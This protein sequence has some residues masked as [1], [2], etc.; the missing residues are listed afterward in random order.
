MCF[1][2]LTRPLRYKPMLQCNRN[3]ALTFVVAASLCAQAPAGPDKISLDQALQLAIVHNH[4]LLA[5][6]TTIVQNQ[7][8]EVQANVRP[9]PTLFTDWEYLPLS[10][11]SGG[12]GSYLQNATE[13]DISTGY[14][15]PRTLPTSR[16]P[17]SG[18]TSEHSHIKSASF[19]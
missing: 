17:R 7:A 18:T 6:R 8:L 16:A 14:R 9:N 19:M 13:G 11:V 5:S 15:R 10:P 1:R 12:I 3:L 2:N 4:S